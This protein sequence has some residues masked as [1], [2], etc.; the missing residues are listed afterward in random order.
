MMHCL[1]ELCET[2]YDRLS[3]FKDSEVCVCR[4]VSI[5]VHSGQVVDP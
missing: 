4:A 3:D 1:R 2:E 5:C